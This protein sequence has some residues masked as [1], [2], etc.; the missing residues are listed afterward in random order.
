MVNVNDENLVDVLTPNDDDYDY[1]DDLEE[2]N[3]ET[4]KLGLT[5]PCVNAEKIIKINYQILFDLEHSII[6]SYY[7]KTSRIFDIVRVLVETTSCLKSF[8]CKGDSTNN[9]KI[10]E[11]LDNSSNKVILKINPKLSLTTSDYYL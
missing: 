7:Y 9:I 2:W 6:G 5:V 4:I 8:V 1:T 3:K 10:D 11:E